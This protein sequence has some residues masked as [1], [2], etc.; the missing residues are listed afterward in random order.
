[1][2]LYFEYNN[3]KCFLREIIEWILVYIICILIFDIII[4]IGIF[5]L[6][7]LFC[8]EY[9][10]VDILFILFDVI[11]IKNNWY[12]KI[13]RNMIIGDVYVIVN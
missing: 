11:I 1:M 6:F 4:N 8:F 2:Y 13:N 5:C 12:K 9:I 3:Y 7:F 10:L